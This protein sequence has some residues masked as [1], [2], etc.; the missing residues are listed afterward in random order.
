MHDIKFTVREI[1]LTRELGI[2]RKEVQAVRD[3]AGLVKGIDWDKVGKPATICLTDHAALTIRSRIG[4]GVVEPETA[5]AASDGVKAV[6]TPNVAANAMILKHGRPPWWT[7]DEATVIKKWTNPSVVEVD[8]GGVRKTCR[9]RDSSLIQIGMVIPVREY[10]NALVI[11]RSP[12]AAGR[13]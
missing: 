12:R 1:D 2:G 9:V 11:A 4:Q 5:K 13:W 8:F 10:G 7:K 3:A 6:M